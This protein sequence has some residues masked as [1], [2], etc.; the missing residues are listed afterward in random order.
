[1]EAGGAR[2]VQ[3]VGELAP[4]SEALTSPELSRIGGGDEAAPDSSAQQLP[5]SGDFYIW[6]SYWLVPLRRSTVGQNGVQAPLLGVLGVWARAPQPDLGAE[7]QGI[8]SAYW[9]SR[10][11]VGGVQHQSSFRRARGWPRRWTS[12]SAC[13]TC[14]AMAGWTSARTRR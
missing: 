2:L 9:A 13:A 14:R 11:R 1:M 4:S 8:R 3:V 5:R 7:E 10:A 12:C 6:R